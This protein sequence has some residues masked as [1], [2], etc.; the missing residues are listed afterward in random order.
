MAEEMMVVEDFTIDSAKTR[1]MAAVLQ[2]IGVADGKT[3]LLIPTMDE[4]LV[5]AGRNIPDLHIRIA[6][7]V[8]TYDILNCRV[9]IIQKSALERIQKVLMP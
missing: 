5:R 3:L 2:G 8:S 9:L 1:D 6:D 7:T 4:A